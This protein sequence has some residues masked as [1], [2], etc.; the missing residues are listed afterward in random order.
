M[1]QPTRAIRHQL[2]LGLNRRPLLL[3]M[4]LRQTGIASLRVSFPVAL[5]TDISTWEV[6]QIQPTSIAPRYGAPS[7]FFVII[8]SDV[9]YQCVLLNGLEP[10]YRPL[11][12][13]TIDAIKEWLLYRP[14]SK[15]G[16]WDVF[17]A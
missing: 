6:P 8:L 14:L 7:S 13:N 11:S 17:V 2:D 16:G 12:E 9:T 1:R 15:D 10:K 5:T 3:Q 4:A